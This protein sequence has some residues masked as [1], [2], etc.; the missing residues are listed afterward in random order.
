MIY[1]KT[2]RTIFNNE[3]LAIAVSESPKFSVLSEM[4]LHAS[5]VG[6]QNISAASQ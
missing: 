6:S 4:N 2:K 3:K 5:K 1:N